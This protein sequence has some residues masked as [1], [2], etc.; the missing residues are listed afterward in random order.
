MFCVILN[1]KKAPEAQGHGEGQRGS[2][3]NIK[4]PNA[5]GLVEGIWVTWI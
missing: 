4:V 2:R 1:L 5:Q 3:S